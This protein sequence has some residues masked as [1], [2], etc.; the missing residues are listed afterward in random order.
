[1]IYSDIL[2]SR[3]NRYSA[4][5]TRSLPCTRGSRPV[6]RR[7]RPAS[8]GWGAP[9]V[10]SWLS[11]TRACRCVWT[12]ICLISLFATPRHVAAVENTNMPAVSSV[13]DSLAIHDVPVAVP[14]PSALATQHYH[15]GNWLWAIGQAW[16]LL[17]PAVLLFSGGSARIRTLAQRLGGGWFRTVALYAVLYIFLNFL[18]DLPLDYYRS[19]IRPHMYGL[20]NQT[21]AKWLHDAFVRL[22]VLALLGVLLLW[23]PYLLINAVRAAGGFMRG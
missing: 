20:S 7:L 1:M 5:E 19:F 17:V 13:A 12:A 2:D 14:E 18:V 21:H 23:I 11:S 16:V 9:G 10:G 8:K 3:T 4:S 22:G 15:S 6:L